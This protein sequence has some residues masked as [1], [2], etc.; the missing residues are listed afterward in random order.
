M[1]I[2]K[3]KTEGL[4]HIFDVTITADEIAKNVETRLDEIVSKV[5]LPGFRPGKAPRDLVKKRYHSGLETEVLDKMLTD[6]VEQVKKE[7]NLRP[8]VQPKF[9][10]DPYVSGKDF[11]VKLTIES[12]P[13]IKV[14]DDDLAKIDVIKTTADVSEHDIQKSID[15]FLKM[16]S[17]YVPMDEKRPAKTDDIAVIDFLGK[18]GGEAFQGGKGEDYPLA[19]GSNTFIPGFEEGVIG[20]SVGDKKDVKVKFPADYHSKELAGSDAIF[21]VTLKQ[22]KKMKT[23]ELNDEFAK[24]LGRKDVADLKEEVKKGIEQQYSAAA[25]TN[26]KRGLF[27]ALDAAFKIELPQTMV[28]AELNGIMQQHEE[29]KKHG[30]LSEEE[31]NK[32]TEQLS[33]EYLEIAK[34][35]VKLGL[36]LAEIGRI[37]NIQLQQADLYRMIADEAMR[38]P[39]QEKEVFDY[40]QKNPKAL[41]SLKAPA[42]EEK[43]V[44]F[45]LSKVK[46]T[47]EKMTAEELF[48]WIDAQDKKEDKKSSA[49]KETAKK[50]K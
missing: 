26:M 20:M 47:E 11:K 46:Q 17:E 35:R 50:G 7:N 41:D 44:D 4:V 40:Y 14:S 3:E 33:K 13:E 39:G 48:G 8:A 43:V 18:V 1:Q 21:E 24:T 16:R 32:T 5:N 15:R 31:K 22:L 37:N 29:E 36:L 23:P 6:L 19:L 2:K 42:F 30:H 45:V 12:F 9:D 28:E 10:G 38:Y 27:D 25:R 34:R 49:K